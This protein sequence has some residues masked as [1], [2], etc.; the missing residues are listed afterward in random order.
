MAV[1]GSVA[2]EVADDLAAGQGQPLVLA[3]RQDLGPVV[4]GQAIGAPRDVVV[5]GRHPARPAML[6]EDRVANADVAQ[7]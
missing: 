2:P 4:E 1:A 7:G 3:A 6:V 5:G